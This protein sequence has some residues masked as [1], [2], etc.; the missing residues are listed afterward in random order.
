M[1]SLSE[2][3]EW[4][5]VVF[6][7][8]GLLLLVLARGLGG[9]LQGRAWLGLWGT[10]LRAAAGPGSPGAEQRSYFPHS[11]PSEGNVGVHV[12]APRVAKYMGAVRSSVRFRLLS[13]RELQLNPIPDESPESSPKLLRVIDYEP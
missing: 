4:H 11:S 7:S 3:R 1:A 10:A 12:D 6:L 9:G 13:R 8:Q 5:L 2:L